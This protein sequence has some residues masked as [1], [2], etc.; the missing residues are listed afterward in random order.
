MSVPPSIN[1]QIILR[2]KVHLPGDK[3][4]EEP[5]QTPPADIETEAE[6]QQPPPRKSGGRGRSGAS[7][8]S[9]VPPNAFQIILEMIDGLRDVQTEHSNSLVAI[10]DQ[11]NLLSAKFDSFTHQP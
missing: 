10:Q 4:V 5:E 2:S 3:Q 11:I 1:S 8:S 7:S 9:S 6:G